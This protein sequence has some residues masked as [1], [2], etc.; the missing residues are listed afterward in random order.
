[1]METGTKTLTP[2]ESTNR[3]TVAEIYSSLATGNMEA[4]AERLAPD[5]KWTVVAGA[6]TGGT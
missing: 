4:F 2:T 3:R 6:E 5:I 1:M